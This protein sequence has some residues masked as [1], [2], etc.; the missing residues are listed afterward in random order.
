MSRKYKSVRAQLVITEAVQVSTCV[1]VA[2]GLS[3]DAVGW[4]ECKRQSVVCY[5]ARDRGA[6]RGET[7]LHG[8][9][10]VV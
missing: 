8:S 7:D 10:R 5:S 1:G 9:V 3:R 6:R 2:V 4:M